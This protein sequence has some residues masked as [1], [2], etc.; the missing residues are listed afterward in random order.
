MDGLLI[1]FEWF[2]A[3]RLSGADRSL[4]TKKLEPSIMHWCG[5]TGYAIDAIGNSP[6]PSL[7][8]HTQLYFTHP[9]LQN[10]S[11]HVRAKQANIYSIYSEQSLIVQGELTLWPIDPPQDLV[12]EL[13]GMHNPRH[14]S[15]TAQAF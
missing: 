12:P 10:K 7:R 9:H 8:E 2:F 6:L 13:K 4:L 11:I 15:V 14:V 5:M 3:V 1:E